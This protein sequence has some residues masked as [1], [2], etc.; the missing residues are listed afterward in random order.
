MKFASAREVNGQLFRWFLLPSWQ[1]LR[2]SYQAPVLR[3]VFSLL[4]VSRH[5]IP[6]EVS[7][8]AHTMSRPGSVPDSSQ[9]FKLSSAKALLRLFFQGLRNFNIMACFEVIILKNPI[10]RAFWVKD[11]ENSNEKEGT[12]TTAMSVFRD[13]DCLSLVVCSN[14]TETSNC[15]VFI[16]FQILRFEIGGAAYQWMRLIHGRLWYVIV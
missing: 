9:H 15:V 13:L 6:E 12:K 2:L 10:E 14:F 5:A 11:G 7:V 1:I 8:Y 4:R 16:F 3:E